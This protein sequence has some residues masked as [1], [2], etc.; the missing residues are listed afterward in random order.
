MHLTSAVVVFLVLR[1]REGELLA[2]VDDYFGSGLT[3]R[4]LVRTGCVCRM[5]LLSMIKQSSVMYMFRRVSGPGCCL[6]CGCLNR[7]RTAP[8]RL[9]C[10]LAGSLT[11]SQPRSSPVCVSYV[12]T[13]LT[14]SALREAYEG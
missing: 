13:R 8:V 6:D 5:L 11:R 10:D 7:E 1:G 4:N 3:G 12:L 2:L 9:T 14:L